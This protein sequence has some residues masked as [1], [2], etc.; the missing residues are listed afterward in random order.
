[1][2]SVII[3]GGLEKKLHMNYWSHLYILSMFK[4]IQ[5]IILFNIKVY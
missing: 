5:N 4:L 1:M 3:H 2:E